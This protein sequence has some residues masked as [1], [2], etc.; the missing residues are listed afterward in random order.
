MEYLLLELHC[1]H[2]CLSLVKSESQTIYIRHVEE[3]EEGLINNSDSFWKIVW[4][5]KRS[6][7]CAALT[8]FFFLRK[9]VLTTGLFSFAMIELM[10]MVMINS[11]LIVMII[12]MNNNDYDDTDDDDDDELAV[13]FFKSL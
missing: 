7:Q 3:N 2:D 13:L 11:R 4:I 1:F 10:M 5:S 9:L 6:M 8:S 12:L